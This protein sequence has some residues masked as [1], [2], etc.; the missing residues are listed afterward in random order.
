MASQLE[1][2]APGEFLYSEASGEYS[3]DNI[4]L[5]SGAGLLPAGRIL[6][7]ITASGKYQSYNVANTPVG[8]G[9]AA[10][11]LYAE[12]DATSADMPAVMISRTAEVVSARISA[13]SGGDKAA[14]I[15]SL[16]AIGVI[17]R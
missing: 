9:T 10:G 5:V 8:T 3:R 12:V 16:A 1:V 17:A 6:G 11:V 14:G 13:A 15:T 7:K 4:T 2:P